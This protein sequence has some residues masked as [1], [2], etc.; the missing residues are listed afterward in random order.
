MKR[1]SKIE[2]AMAAAKLS[3]DLMCGRGL[4]NAKLIIAEAKRLLLTEEK[5]R[6][7]LK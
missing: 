7:G 4:R 5:R 1:M 2:I 6:K 3:D